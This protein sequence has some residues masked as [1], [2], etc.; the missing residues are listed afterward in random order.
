MTFVA[1]ADNYVTSDG[2]EVK[3]EDID[4]SMLIHSRVNAG[5]ITA[6][7]NQR[8]AILP[9]LRTGLTSGFRLSCRTGLLLAALYSCFVCFRR[10]AGRQNG[11]RAA[12]Q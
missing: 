9:G 8:S 5:I 7:V 1:K 2:K 10:T 3:K 12:C 11:H 6:A 4:L